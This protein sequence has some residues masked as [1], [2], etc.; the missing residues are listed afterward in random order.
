M[1]QSTT[2]ATA[3]TAIMMIAGI[4]ILITTAVSGFSIITQA[5]DSRVDKTQIMVHERMA[6]TGWRLDDAQTLRLNVT[7]A[8]ETSLALRDFDKFDLI[9]T[10]LEA[11]VTRSE[12]LAFDQGASSGDYW[13]VNRVFF[14]GAEG[15]QVNP[16]VLN[17]QVSGNW[18]PGE[19]IE[20]LVHIDAVSPTYRYLMYSTLNG[21]TV[22]TGLTLSYQ[23]GTASIASGSVSIV[24]PHNLGRV[25]V[26]V[27]VTPR[28]NMTS[29]SF[30]VSNVDSDSFTVNLSQVEPEDIGFY[31]RIE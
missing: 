30:W 10:Y 2:V 15:D 11:G 18:D 8:G 28:N 16:I 12:W 7:N 20:L 24:V 27:Q 13:M 25:P 6:F 31:W 5:I 26:N 9:V 1:G 4:A 14:N 23:S 29:P 19:T 3:F 22:S 21:V 17:S